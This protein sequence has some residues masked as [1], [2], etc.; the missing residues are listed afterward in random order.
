MG[1]TRSRV[2]AGIPP[3]RETY[4]ESKMLVRKFTL[5]ATGAALAL[6]ALTFATNAPAQA[7]VLTSAVSMLSTCRDAV[8]DLAKVDAVARDSHWAPEPSPTGGAFKVLSAW[9]VSQREG[10]FIVATGTTLS[11]THNVCMLAFPQPTVSRDELLKRVA[12]IMPVKPQS[13]AAYPPLQTEMFELEGAPTKLRMQIVTREGT[14]TAV[15][16]IGM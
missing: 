1:I 16:I 12:A 13:A 4:Q 7:D 6:S 3:A 15:G 11:G 8:T 14:V 5:A 9:R 10:D 2:A